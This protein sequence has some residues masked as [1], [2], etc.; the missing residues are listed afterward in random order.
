MATELQPANIN[1]SSIKVKVDNREDMEALIE[2]FPTEDNTRE[3]TV[4][5]VRPIISDN[6]YFT[7]FNSIMDLFEVLSGIAFIV[8]IIFAIF[9][10]ILL[11]NF[12][13]TSIFH[14]KK[15][16]WYFKRIRC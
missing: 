8:S 2:T 3:I 1:I 14:S 12:I 6:S 9:A 4:D 11:M 16:H 5:T 7:Y 13:I 10:I 15:D